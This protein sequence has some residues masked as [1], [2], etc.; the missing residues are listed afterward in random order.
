MLSSSIIRIKIAYYFLKYLV[1]VFFIS[2]VSSILRFSEYVDTSKTIYSFI[3]VL[4][5]FVL[6]R[7]INFYFVKWINKSNMSSL[8]GPWCPQNYGIREKLYDFLAIGLFVPVQLLLS[9][10]FGI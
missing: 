3:E 1:P 5:F 2:I 6:I 10:L 8:L 9:K 4:A 7:M